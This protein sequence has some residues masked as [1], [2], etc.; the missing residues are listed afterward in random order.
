MRPFV[1]AARSPPRMLAAYQASKRGGG[2]GERH[3]V[4]RIPRTIA[5]VH[6]SMLARLHIIVKA[7]M[8]ASVIAHMIVIT[9]C[10]R[11]ARDSEKDRATG[12]Q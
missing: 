4:F 9:V 2:R 10:G 3:G 8:I 11:G 7:A 1:G 12:A 6:I 5:S